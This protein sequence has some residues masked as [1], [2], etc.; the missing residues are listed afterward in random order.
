MKKFALLLTAMT[1]SASLVACGGGDSE[2]SPAPGQADTSTFT[3]ILNEKKDFMVV[4]NSEDGTKSYIF[5]MDGI[6][7][8]AETGDKVTVTY[9]GDIDDID[10]RLDATKIEATE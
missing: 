9:T 2:S 8:D 6:T 10:S 7:C 5:N 4:V 3:G 1:L